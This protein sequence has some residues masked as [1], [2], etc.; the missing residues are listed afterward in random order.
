MPIQAP[1]KVSPP[2]ALRQ[3]D[4]S[5]LYPT[6]RPSDVFLCAY[7]KSGTHWLAFLL[8]HI[9][10]N[11]QGQTIDLKSI[12]TFVPDVNLIYTKRGSLTQYDNFSNPR[13]FR[14]HAAYDPNLPR[15]IYVIRDPRDVLLSYWHY[16]KFLSKDFSQ[17]LTDYLRGD[18]FW[19]CRWDDHVSSWLLPQTNLNRHP[20][21]LVVK[22]ERLHQDTA[23]VLRE[24]LNFCAINATG[25]AI[26]RAVERSS[27]HRMQAMEKKF[28]VHGKNGHESESFVRKGKTG[29]WREEMSDPDAQIITE[30]YGAVMRQ[31]GYSPSGRPE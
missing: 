4:H 2:R 25:D 30:K 27:F 16:Q 17:T 21:L 10:E 23:D 24:V 22:Y 12:D 8:G 14:C 3:Y 26:A 1:P 29:S 7:P 20:N 6:I 18:D 9:L 31:V 11:D 5:A 13:F 19:P 15:V 28:G